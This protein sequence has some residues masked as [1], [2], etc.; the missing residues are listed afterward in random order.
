[1]DSRLAGIKGVMPYFDD[2]LIVAESADQLEVKLKS[3]LKRFKE[4]DYGFVQINANFLSNTTQ[5]VAM[6]SDFVIV[7]YKLAY[8]PGTQIPHADALSLLPLTSPDIDGPPLQEVLMLE[9]VPEKSFTA[10]EIAKKTKEKEYYRKYH[11]GYKQVGRRR[12]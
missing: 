7:Y 8:V 6:D 12:H 5:N 11:F 1:M 2:V 10:E 9:S 3:V 4:I